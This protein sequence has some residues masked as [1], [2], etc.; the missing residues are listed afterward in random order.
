MKTNTLFVILSALVLIPLLN[1]QIVEAKRSEIDEPLIVGANLSDYRPQV[2]SKCD[3]RVPKQYQTIQAA[4]DAANPGDTVCVNKGVYN[5]NLHI[6]KSITLSGRGYDK[7]IINGIT[8]PTEGGDL[9]TVS[10]NYSNL[11]TPVDGVILE[12]F[13]INGVDRVGYDTSAV[14]IW[15]N[16]LNTIVRY[17][18]I[19]SGNGG[20][21]L[22]AGGN[23]DLMQNNVF[24]GNSSKDIVASGEHILDWRILNNTFIGTIDSLVDDNHGRVIS[25]WA[26]NGLI[27]QNSF[28][29]QIGLKTIVSIAHQYQTIIENNFNGLYTSDYWKIVANDVTAINNW[30]GEAADPAISIRFPE[31]T[32]YIPFRT[33]PYPEYPIPVLN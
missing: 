10:V 19:V 28:N 13:R 9:Y 20:I 6:I 25:F 1:I 12:G 29:V 32:T 3:I 15:P 17:N 26:D 18:H 5:E 16:S 7:T 33:T 30:W 4:I 24:E 23:Y 2:P 31:T 22:I 8:P 21:A 27:K 11:S 14:I